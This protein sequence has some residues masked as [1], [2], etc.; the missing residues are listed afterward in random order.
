MIINV[1]VINFLR[2]VH[3]LTP[4]WDRTRLFEEKYNCKI[5]DKSADIIN[6]S[7]IKLEF[8][9]EKNGVVFMLRYM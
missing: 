8:D 2:L 5:V 7:G 6:A 1:P 3:P 9:D 4:A